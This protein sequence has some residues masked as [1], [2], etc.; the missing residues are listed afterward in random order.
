MI[1]IQLYKLS[2]YRST[3]LNVWCNFQNRVQPLVI[4]HATRERC[5][6]FGNMYNDLRKVMI[7]VP[8][9]PLLVVL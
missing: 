5:I 8:G 9:S 7:V 6:L 3:W 4:Y 2:K 1:L